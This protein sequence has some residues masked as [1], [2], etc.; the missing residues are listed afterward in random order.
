M[1]C[2]QIVLNVKT[3]TKKSSYWLLMRASDKNLPV[4]PQQFSN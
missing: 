1:L 4:N 2:T 3:K